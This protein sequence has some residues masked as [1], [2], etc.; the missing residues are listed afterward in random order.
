MTWR[1]ACPSLEFSEACRHRFAAVLSHLVVGLSQV[2]NEHRD[3]VVSGQLSDLL[4]VVI[5][6][7]RFRVKAVKTLT[8]SG[9]LNP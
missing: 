7:E 5:D 2:A 9:V 8:A 4:F 6:A 1:P 3:H